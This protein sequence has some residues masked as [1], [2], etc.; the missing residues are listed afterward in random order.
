MAIERIRL[1]TEYKADGLGETKPVLRIGGKTEKFVPNVNLSFQCESGS[2][3]YFLNINR[4]YG[5][6]DYGSEDVTIF[7]LAARHIARA[8]EVGRAV[9]SAA[10]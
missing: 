2:E 9:S 8:I 6:D 3:K 1:T 5:A 4:K 10:L 7:L